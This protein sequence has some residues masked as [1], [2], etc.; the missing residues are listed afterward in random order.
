MLLR[1]VANLIQKAFIVEGL[2]LSKDEEV[3]LMSCESI[4]KLITDKYE[5][6]AANLVK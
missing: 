3:L 5:F 2:K 1:C 6:I 4:E